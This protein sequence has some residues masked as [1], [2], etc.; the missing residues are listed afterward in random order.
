MSFNNIV[1]MA[2]TKC[3]EDRVCNGGLIMYLAKRTTIPCTSIIAFIRGNK[4]LKE[5]ELIQIQKELIK[6]GGDK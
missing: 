1:R 4:D 6:L 5:G 2:L 3:I